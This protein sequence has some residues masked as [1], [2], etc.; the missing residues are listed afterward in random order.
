MGAVVATITVTD[1]VPLPLICTDELERLQVGA[2]LTT[3]VMA[4]LRLTVPVKAPD[5]VTTKLNVAFCPALISSEV[6][7]PDAGVILKSG[8]A[9]PIPDKGTA[10]GLPGTLSLMVR[11]PVRLPVALGVKS[12]EIRQVLPDASDMQV[13]VS[14]KSPEAEMLVIL[15]G[16]FPVLVRVTT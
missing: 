5:G 4:Q 13:L 15:S 14:A 2:G 9:V 6:G 8:A 3:G 10:C 11:E 7:D 12:T 1:C 16:V